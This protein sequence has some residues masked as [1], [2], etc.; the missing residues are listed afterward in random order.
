M[1][2]MKY[3]VA[4]PLH[5]EFRTLPMV[6]FI[7]P[8]SPLLNA[9]NP[10]TDETDPDE[11]FPAIEH[12]R[13]PVEYLAHLLSAGDTEVIR[14]VLKRLTAMR[15]H[16]RKREVGGVVEEQYAAEVGMSVSDIE[17]MYRLLAIAK[18]DDRYVIPKAHTELAD[19][20]MEQRGT[21][22]LDFDG[23]PGNCGAVAAPNRP[24][25]N[26]FMLLKSVENR[27]L[28][29]Q[30]YEQAEESD[31]SGIDLLRMASPLRLDPEVAG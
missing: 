13:I 2:A 23:G 19:R 22:G 7:P 20:L 26:T 27:E 12:M 4:L 17:A 24:F 14:H 11:V 10:N 31:A 9:V 28:P 5:P 25:A 18:Y 15:R 16:M 1:L 6:W 30:V 8:L 21:C 3:Q 29:N